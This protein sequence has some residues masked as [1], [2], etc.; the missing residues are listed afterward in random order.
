M[1]CIYIYIYIY[2]IVVVTIIVVIIVMPC[3]M[4][5]CYSGGALAVARAPSPPRTPVPGE[6]LCPVEKMMW[7]WRVLPG[8]VLGLARCPLVACTKH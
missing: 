3:T 8:S 4:I 7:R 6:G 1:L 5:T 2:I